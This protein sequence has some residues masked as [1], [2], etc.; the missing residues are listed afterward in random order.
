MSV[1][2]PVAPA[3]GEIL[4]VSRLR[5][6]REV[7]LVGRLHAQVASMIG[8]AVDAASPE[9]IRMLLAEQLPIAFERER[10]LLTRADRMRISEAVFAETAGYGPIQDLLQDDGISEVMVNGPDQVWIERDGQL[11][12]TDVRFFDSAHVLRVIQRIIAPLGRRCDESSPMVDARLPD[13]SRVNAVIPPLSLVGPVLTV[14]KFRRVALAPDHLVSNG[15]VGADALD[16]LRR[17]VA[18]RL[19]IV[20]AGGSGAGK[21][22]LLNALSSFIGPRE[23]IITIEDAA[24]LKLQQRHTIGL[25]TRPPNAE[26]TGQVTMRDLVR[27]ALRMRPDRLVIGECRGAETVDMLQAMNT[28]HDGSMTTVHANGA[29][30]ALSRIE[31]MVLLGTGDLPLRAV[32]EQIV[33]AIDMVVFVERSRDGRR[34]VTH[35]AEV[36]D[37]DGDR[38]AIDDAF[39]ADEGGVLRPTGRGRRSAAKLRARGM[40]A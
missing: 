13:G 28:G 12:L 4:K 33:A 23:R 21:T 25:E 30:D 9:A 20:V 15:T 31:T 1:T 16:H 6:E 32:R 5:D 36:A 24:E 19:N 40:A 35:I 7:E 39:V 14:R 10:M 29:R 37:L 22:T 17:C 34:R 38:L 2:F 8:S 26:G 11:Q 18:A 27:N 3:E